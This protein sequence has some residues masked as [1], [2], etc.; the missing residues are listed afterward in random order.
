MGRKNYAHELK[1]A[2]A[3]GQARDYR[4]AVDILL[5]IISESDSE[6][7][8]YLYLG[9]SYHALGRHDLAVQY[10]SYFVKREKASGA[11]FFFLGRSYLAS[12]FY[13][14]AIGFLKR[15]LE[16]SG[17]SAQIK[18]YI[19]I[20]YLKL[21]RPDLS[22]RYLGEAV[23]GLPEN[24]KVY[25]AYL[26]AL[27][28]QGTRLFYRGDL[29]TA[30][31]MFSFIE[32]Q[33]V[34]SVLLHLFLAI[35]EREARN[36]NEAVRHYDEALKLTPDDALIRFKRAV[37]LRESGRGAEAEA[38]LSQLDI[39]AEMKDLSLDAETVNRFLAIQHFEKKEF[40]KAAFYGVEVLKSSPKDPSMHILVGESYRSV[41]EF[42]KAK[43]HF[44]RVL[45]TDTNSVNARYG[46][47]MVLWQQEL[48]DDML[49]ELNLIDRL[50][51]G[52][53]I[54]SYYRSLCACRLEFSPA[55]TIPLVQKEI[56][57]SGPDVF[58]LTELG[59][60]YIRGGTPELAPKWFQKTLSIDGSFREAL[61]GL[62]IAYKASGETSR[63][64]KSYHDYL[65]AYPDDEGTRKEY[66]LHLNEVRNYGELAFQIEQFIPFASSDE[67]M[68][69]LLALS[70]RKTE[71]YK[72]SAV[73]YRQLLIK[74]P[75]NEIYIRSLAYCLEKG[76]R[77][78]TAIQ[79]LDKAMRFVKPSNTLLLI[80]GVM[81]YKDSDD[82][83]ALSQFRTVI[84]RDKTDWR[85]YYNMSMIYKRKGIED[86]SQ[87]YLRLAEQHKNR[88]A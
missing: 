24:K 55:K 42:E 52:N 32:A 85:A 44:V 20:A 79:L 86:F 58:L 59:K 53:A 4:K 3:A 31:Q 47:A 34:S 26:N 69:R 18:S 73:I 88:K 12:G 60:Q 19:G 37:L 33:G 46:I 64:S 80:Y 65:A 16:L 27:F 57:K 1:Q 68:Q 74:R 84:E 76:G 29:D 6:P 10:L 56:Q 71:R 22:I 87:K 7:K 49:K 77:L 72:E 35:I 38:E 66:I 2:L 61:W 41:G 17:G 14:E 62:I 81:L 25:T 5:G 39:L 82:E 70:Y 45:D 23:E 40:R 8:A 51:P 28:V 75:D 43:N 11:G 36:I 54:V 9:R 13:R 48:Y 50:D 15:A 63:L 83:K 67:K 30:R 78:K 21:K